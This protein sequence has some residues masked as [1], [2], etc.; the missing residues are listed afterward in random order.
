VD[1]PESNTTRTYTH[2]T[3]PLFPSPTCT[4]PPPLHPLQC[5][6]PV[7]PA[8]RYSVS[9]TA[10]FG[11]VTACRCSRGV[12]RLIV[13]TVDHAPDRNSVARQ[14]RESFVCKE[15]AASA[16]FL[17]SPPSWVVPREVI[18]CGFFPSR[19]CPPRRPGRVSEA[20]LTRTHRSSVLYVAMG[21]CCPPAEA[22]AVHQRISRPSVARPGLAH[23][24]ASILVRFCAVG[25]GP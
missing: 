17:Y 12:A 6:A 15:L 21:R 16:L 11:P 25:H 20:I 18:Q 23:E 19:S 7:L 22:A 14:D 10:S 4:H 3:A 24:S 5:S 1:R 2:S 8:G 13:S 9:R